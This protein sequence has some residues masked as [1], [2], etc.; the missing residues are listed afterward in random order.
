MTDYSQCIYAITKQV[1][2][3]VDPETA[4]EKNPIEAIVVRRQ[5]SYFGDQEGMIGLMMHLEDSPWIGYLN[6]VIA[7]FN[8][9]YPKESLRLWHH[10]DE[11]FKD[12]LMK[13]MSMDPK[14]RITAEE[15]LAHKWF[16]DVP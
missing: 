8:E 15:A 2:L 5:V 16:A 13:M 1:V 10:L 12:L 3:F 4:T 11:D 9:D 14:R 7:N 6:F